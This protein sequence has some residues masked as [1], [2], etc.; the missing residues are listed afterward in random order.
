MFADIAEQ[1]SDVVIVK[2]VKRLSALTSHANQVRRAQQAELVGH[3]RLGVVD[4]RGQV[5]HTVF[6]LHQGFKE[7]DA[8]GV[9]QQSEGRGDG[10]EVSFGGGGSHNT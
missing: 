5:G 7:S 6:A 4:G 9:A 10:L 1:A 2:G 3:G 8:C